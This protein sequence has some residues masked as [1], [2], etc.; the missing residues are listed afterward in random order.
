MLILLY[1]SYFFSDQGAST[2]IHVTPAHGQEKKERLKSIQIP[3]TQKKLITEKRLVH[4]LL[5]SSTYEEQTKNLN[6]AKREH[7]ST[8]LRMIKDCFEDTSILNKY[9]VKDKKYLTGK[10]NHV[11]AAIEKVKT[12]NLRKEDIVQI[13]STIASIDNG[14]VLKILLKSYVTVS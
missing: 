14:K 1:V 10:K 6:D 3:V 9:S 11:V 7:L 13:M 4:S 5:R 12:S 8:I 2:D